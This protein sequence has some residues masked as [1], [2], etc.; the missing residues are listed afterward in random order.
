MVYVG[1]WRFYFWIFEEIQA[2]GCLTCLSSVPEVK[3][4]PL[5]DAMTCDKI[6]VDKCE[7]HYYS[8]YV[9]QQRED[10]KCVV[11]NEKC[12]RDDEE[13]TSAATATQS[14]T[15]LVAIS[16]AVIAYELIKGKKIK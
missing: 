10:Y 14:S 13:C 7:A 12:Q 2:A 4:T 8:K 9:Q 6:E 3:T 16:V 5:A 11:K 15:L 1:K